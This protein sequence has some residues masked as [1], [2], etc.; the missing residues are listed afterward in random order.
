MYRYLC[1]K[2]CTGIRF[3][4]PN[5]LTSRGGGGKGKHR[6][7]SRGYH[8]LTLGS[9]A[10]I[11]PRV[12]EKKIVPLVCEYKVDKVIDGMSSTWGC[13]AFGLD[14]NRVLHNYIVN[15]YI[16]SLSSGIFQFR[17][18]GDN[19]F[20]Y[21]MLLLHSGVAARNMTR[22]WKAGNFGSTCMVLKKQNLQM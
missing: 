13:A 22:C 14:L 20:G 8:G 10:H 16:S 2:S 6:M 19:S 3:V 7:S 12:Q 1:N 15:T 5:N 11:L 18:E 9:V 17:E 21:C 4:C